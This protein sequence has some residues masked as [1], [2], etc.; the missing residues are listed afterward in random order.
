M[1]VINNDCVVAPDTLRELLRRAESR[2]AGIACPKVL[3]YNQR[4]LIQYAGYRNIHILAQGVAVGEGEPDHGQYDTERICNAAP[5]CALLLTARLI[6]DVGLFD[7]QF[8]AY[9]EEL[10]FCRRA[11]RRG[12]KILYV[13]SARV[14]HRKGATLTHASPDYMYHLTRGRLLYARKHLGF[15][16]FTF[17]FLPYFIVVKCLKPCVLYGLTGRTAH[18]NALMRAVGWHARNRV[19]RP[20]AGEEGAAGR[21]GE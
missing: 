1:T 15:F 14:W 10:D 21:R 3:D 11:T 6:R 8:F 19:R 12:F 9:S 16:P 2:S 17:V 13:P 7:E 20:A 18:C 4:T 5:G